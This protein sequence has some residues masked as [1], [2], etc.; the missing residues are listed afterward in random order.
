MKDQLR[1]TSK[2]IKTNTS[3]DDNSNKTTLQ[4]DEVLEQLKCTDGHAARNVFKK[5]QSI[6]DRCSPNTSSGDLKC[7]IPV[8]PGVQDY[9]RDVRG[10]L[11][12]NVKTPIEKPLFKAEMLS[13]QLRSF[14]ATTNHLTNG[15]S[16]EELLIV[17]AEE[18]RTKAQANIARIESEKLKGEF[19]ENKKISQKVKNL[20]KTCDLRAVSEETFKLRVANLHIL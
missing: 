20:E 2:E 9:S 17:K 3:N 13:A 15:F 1:E 8:S 6:I 12:I 7:S 14:V 4:C 16:K 18:R 10:S 5:R 19:V 11:P